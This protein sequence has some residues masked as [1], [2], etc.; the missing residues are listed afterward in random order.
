MWPRSEQRTYMPCQLTTNNDIFKFKLTKVNKFNST[1]NEV[2][3]QATAEAPPRLAME[4]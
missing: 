1:E 2:D 3:N 4:I